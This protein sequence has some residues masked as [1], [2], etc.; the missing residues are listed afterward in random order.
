MCEYFEYVNI[1]NSIINLGLVTSSLEQNHN[2]K[3]VAQQNS[4]NILQ[5]AENVDDTK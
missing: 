4:L 3:N 2:K 5:C 1:S